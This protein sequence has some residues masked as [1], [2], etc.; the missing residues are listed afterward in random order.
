MAKLDGD[1]RQSTSLLALFNLLSEVAG[2]LGVSE[3]DL[4]EVLPPRP[5]P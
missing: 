4:R 5:T 2:E 1:R 3:A